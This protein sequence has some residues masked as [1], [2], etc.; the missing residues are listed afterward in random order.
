MEEAVW[1]PVLGHQ[2]SFVGDCW[3]PEVCVDSCKNVKRRQAEYL[4]KP[5]RSWLAAGQAGIDEASPVGKAGASAKRTIRLTS[6]DNEDNS[7]EPDEVNRMSPTIGD[8]YKG[9]DEA[10]RVV[11]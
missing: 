11:S 5:P 3:N 2:N 4:G 10:T 6:S 7:E 8:Q 9:S 1:R